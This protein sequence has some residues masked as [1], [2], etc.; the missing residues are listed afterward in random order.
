VGIYAERLLDNPL[1]W[2]KM[3]AVYRLL[4]LARR[5]GDEAV[6]TACGKALEVDVISVA[7]IASMLERATQNNPVPPPRPAAVAGGRF[8]RH[9]DEYATTTR[10]RLV[11]DKGV[12]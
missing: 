5:H 8:A 2:T 6:N 11:D 1:P 10:L 3:R 4:G 9:P 7:K 12:R